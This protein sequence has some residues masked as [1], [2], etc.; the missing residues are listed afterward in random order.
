M[1]VKVNE[2]RMMRELRELAAFT[3]PSA[4][5]AREGETAVTRVVFTERDR[6]ARAWLKKLAAETGLAV[7]EDAVGNTFFRWEGAEPALAAVATGSHIDAIPNAGMYDGTVGV[8]GGLEAIRALQATGFQPRRSVELILFTSEEPTRFGI[9]CLGSRLMSG[10]LGAEAARGLVDD[11]GVS[12]DEARTGAGYPGELGAVTLAKGAYAGFV[13][14]HIEQGP[15]LEREGVPIGVVTQIA[16]P[17]SG[18]ITV[19]GEGGHAGA[20]LMPVRH[21]ALVAAAEVVLAVERAALATGAEDTVATV[22]RCEVFPGA[23]NSVPSRVRLSLDVRDVDLGRRDAVL[24]A[25]RSACEDVAGQR[26]VTIT[27]TMLNADEPASCA[28]AVV[29]AIEAACAEAGVTRMRMVSRAYHDALFMARVCP[30][31]M[32]F[33]PCRGGVS[34]RPDEYAEVADLAAGVRVLAQTLATLSL[35]EAL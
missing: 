35:G 22:G 28:A 6:E 10:A 7:R 24:A 13:E 15:R 27:P 21:D 16:A 17:A 26:G 18:M 4:E 23:V 19:E 20:L 30:V 34:H 3:E 25:I 8:L 33:V 32:I 2:R 14:L 31:G 12:L 11:G 1:N 5:P 29:N 9:G